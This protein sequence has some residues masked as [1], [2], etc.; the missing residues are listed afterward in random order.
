MNRYGI[1]TLNK[2]YISVGDYLISKYGE[3]DVV[4]SIVY[5]V[6]NNGC[7][8][9]MNPELRI[10]GKIG[11]REA[12]DE[13]QSGRQ[14]EMIICEIDM[15]SIKGMRANDK[16]PSVIKFYKDL[17]YRTGALHVGGDKANILPDLFNSKNYQLS[18][19]SLLNLSKHYVPRRILQETL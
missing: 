16:L 8:L 11:F 4:A 9:H 6:Y 18:V 7:V 15:D 12:V 13:I 17:V 19:Q 3:D 14:L 5:R 2:K 10:Q 1:P